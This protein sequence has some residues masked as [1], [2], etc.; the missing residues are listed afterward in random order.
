M[1]AQPATGGG[2]GDLIS[3]DEHLRRILGRI[4]PLDPFPQP[5][6]E[7]V[8]LP[9]RADVVAPVSLPM[10]SNSAMDGY[11]V[12]FRDVA[13]ARPD[14]PIVLPVTGEIV[15]GT[16]GPPL[17][18]GTAVSI[19]TG[20]AVPEGAT[21]VVPFEWTELDGHEVRIMRAPEEGQHVREAGEEIARGDVLLRAGQV[22]G[23]REVGVVAAVGVSRVQAVARPRVVIVSTGA[24]LVEPGRQAG[25]DQIYDAN[26]FLLA[27]AVRAHGGIP[28]RVTC[29]SD[30]PDEFTEVLSDQLV[31]ADVIVTSGGVSK[32]TRDVVKEVLASLP[33]VDFGEVAMQPGKPQGFGTV[34]EDSV[35]IFTLP[36]NPV[37]S[38]VSFEVLVVPALRKL[39]GRDPIE[40][41]LTTG[42]V[43]RG[44]LSPRG[45]RQYLRATA[46]VGARGLVVT[47]V[48]GAGSHLIGGLA[49]A[50]ALIVLGEEV[51]HVDAGDQ[52]S[53]LLLDGED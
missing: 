16:S 29:S 27:A 17:P 12:H 37:S 13:D 14:R 15:A 22:L 2:S 49:R 50:D 6:L 40:R 31:R 51:A 47:P 4:T 44:L 38:Y 41:R 24:E 21:A 25:L 36:G 7:A 9:V 10:F 11:A 48:G 8:G 30:D 52:V 46:E 28:Y 42:R 18:P 39:V 45:K 33:T 5:L 3:V 34:G 26:S 53:V 32:G 35:P 19:M 1:S 43:D 23:T 20:A